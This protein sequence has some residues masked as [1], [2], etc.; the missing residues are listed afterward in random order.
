MRGAGRGPGK[1]GQYRV[2]RRRRRGGGEHGTGVA[3]GAQARGG[4]GR[5]PR[6]RLDRREER[7]LAG[8]HRPHT[9][10]GGEG[11]A[12]ATGWCFILML[13]VP[14]MDRERGG[15]RVGDRGVHNKKKGASAMGGTE[16]RRGGGVGEAMR[17]M[18]EEG[19]AGRGDGMGGGRTDGRESRYDPTPKGRGGRADGVERNGYLA[20]EVRGIGDGPVA[21]LRYF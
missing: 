16:E 12:A 10:R 13:P 4:G 8:R 5:A 18:R 17:A 7:E 9:S 6:P 11:V 1:G 21:R 3:A 20:G 2:G 14:D 15:I 19:A